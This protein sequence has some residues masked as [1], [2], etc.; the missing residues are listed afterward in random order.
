MSIEHEMT[1]KEKGSRI[2]TVYW[3]GVLLWA[4]L[5]FGAD[6]LGYLPQIGEADAWSWAF[7][8]AGIFGLLG[9]LYRAYSPN[10]P[11][12]NTWD[13]IWS[14]GL[15]VLG[16]AGFTSLDVGFPLVLLLVGV[17]LLGSAVLRR[18]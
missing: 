2:D 11:N 1:P 17:I 4:G 10:L 9:S 7:A 16:L 14:G 8:G 3:G 15:T 12:P 13:Y 18:E 5:V 6:S